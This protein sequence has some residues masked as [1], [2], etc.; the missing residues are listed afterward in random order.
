MLTPLLDLDSEMVYEMDC[1]KIIDVESKCC[2]CWM[3]NTG[4]GE[5][6]A[7]SE[8]QNDLQLLIKCCY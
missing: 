4:D 7:R 1:E 6:Q 5:A 2:S 3:E 8:A